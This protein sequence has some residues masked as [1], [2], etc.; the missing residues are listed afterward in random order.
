M[1]TENRRKPTQRGPKPPRATVSRT[2]KL[3]Q[4][5]QN[6]AGV[7]RGA[8]KGPLGARK[9][10]IMAEHRVRKGETLI[11]IARLYYGRGQQEHLKIIQEANS[12]LIKDVNVIK[13]G[14][15]FKIP[16]L[17]PHLKN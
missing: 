3:K 10:V 13:E 9:Q 4:P 17:P 6:P 16:Q 14:Q 11:Q 2:G 7:S 12:D 8:S 1:A 5:G 15:V